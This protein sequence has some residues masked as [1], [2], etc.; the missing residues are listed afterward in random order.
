[1]HHCLIARVGK[2]SVNHEVSCQLRNGF[3]VSTSEKSAAEGLFN[4]SEVE[5]FVSLI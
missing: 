3:R 4:L 2:K 5:D 1:M